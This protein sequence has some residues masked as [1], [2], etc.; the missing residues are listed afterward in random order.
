[1]LSDEVIISIISAI[2]GVVTTAIPFII[3]N[4]NATNNNTNDEVKIRKLVNHHFFNSI[5]ILITEVN[6]NFYFKNKGKELIAK[7]IITVQMSDLKESL[8][9]VAEKVDNGHIQDEEHLYNTCLQVYNKNITLMHSF[10]KDSNKYTKEESYALDMVIFKYD[11][12]NDSK[13]NV[14]DNIRSCCYSN[15][16]KDIQTKF[17]VILDLYLYVASSTINLMEKTI[18]SLNGDLKTLVFKGVTI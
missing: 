11:Q 3:K 10:Y 6:T 17:S 1:M 8:L 18:T 9:E 5:D 2:C 16:Y 7:E 12:W 15:S 14:L 4:K 13:E